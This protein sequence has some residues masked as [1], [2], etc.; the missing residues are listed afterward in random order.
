M[1]KGDIRVR[2]LKNGEIKK[3][4]DYDSGIYIFV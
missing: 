3:Y 2:L 4:M 1:R